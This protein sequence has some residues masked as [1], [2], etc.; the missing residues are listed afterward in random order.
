MGNA[1]I[2]VLNWLFTR[3]QGGQFILRIEDTDT[4]RNVPGAE[5]QIEEDLSWLGL[6]W[7]EGPAAPESPGGR[8]GPYR[9]SERTALYHDYAL[10]LL[11]GGH[12]YHC[13]CRQSELDAAREAGM[14]TVLLDRRE[15][16][17]QPRTGDAANG[18]LRVE[19]FADIAA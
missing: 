5:H 6:D 15:D 11:S 19:S 16:Y 4:A 17:P 12:V 9:Q 10:R 1:R 14:R 7:D 13:Y 3:K 8:F 2:A 18:H